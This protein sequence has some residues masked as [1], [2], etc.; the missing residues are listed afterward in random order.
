[1]FFK[2]FFIALST[3]S[4]VPVPQ[5][6]W[7]EDNLRYSICFF[8][9]VGLLCGGALTGWLAFCSA[10]DIGRILCAAVA[11]CIP[12]LLSGGIHMD[13]YM[14]TVDALAS[15]QPRE[16]KLAILKDPNCG[17]FAVAYCGV[18][19]V[20][21][22]GLMCELRDTGLLVAV[23]PG[24][25]LSRALSGLCAVTL[26]NA[27]GSGMLNSYTQRARKK[28]ASAVMVVTSVLASAVMT[29]LAPLP[30]LLAAVLSVLWV[31]LYRRMVMHQFGGVTGDT[32]GF[33]LQVCELAVLLG[34]WMGG[35]LP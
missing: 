13:G 6:E 16:K 4:I 33:F 2:P 25:V 14:D 5:F 27:R 32:A 30:G 21:C 34:I 15:H 31:F 19:L 24:F 29:A 8:P 20:L 28:L 22:F 35:L 3:Y 26:P 11:V 17:A 12:L 10:L 9:L 23:C 18:Y 7:T 1:M